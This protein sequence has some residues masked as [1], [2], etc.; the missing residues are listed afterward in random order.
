MFHEAWTA[1]CQTVEQSVNVPEV[2]ADSDAYRSW[3]LAHV[4][5]QLSVNQQRLLELT[6]S[7]YGQLLQQD[8]NPLL[9][10][11]DFPHRCQQE[12]PVTL[13]TGRRWSNTVHHYVHALDHCTNETILTHEILILRSLLSPSAAASDVSI[14]GTSVND[15]LK[16][17]R[18]GHRLRHRLYQWLKY[19]LQRWHEVIGIAPVS[20]V[21]FSPLSPSNIPSDYPEMVKS[22]AI[23]AQHLLPAV[24]Q[25]TLSVE[26]RMIITDEI[27]HYLER[28]MVIAHPDQHPAIQQMAMHHLMQE[29]DMAY[30]E[31]NNIAVAVICF[32]RAVEI[33]RAISPVFGSH[34]LIQPLTMLA[35]VQALNRD[36]ASALS[37]YE[38]ATTYGRRQWGPWHLALAHLY[39]NYARACYEADNLQR[40]EQLIQNVESILT[41]HHSD[42]GESDSLEFLRSKV[43][44][45][46]QDMQSKH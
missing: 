14:D 3:L 46:R 43:S 40:S 39:Y 9:R 18:L 8:F 29:G 37:L 5:H 42:E 38:E 16:T 32:E 30:Q 33:A 12:S 10:C 44:S 7:V 23:A 20:S 11:L 19:Q 17:S 24:P 15:R 22:V 21:D 28:M 6:I 27:E 45:L 4:P 13:E 36:F 31:L 41:V 25:Q 26:D 34:H 2:A 1:V 35:N